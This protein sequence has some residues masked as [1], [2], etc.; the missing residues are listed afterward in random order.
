MENQKGAALTYIE[1]NRQISKEGYS[2]EH[3][4]THEEFEI[5]FAALCYEQR[6]DQRN[7]PGGD[8]DLFMAVPLDWPWDEED[9]KPSPDDRIKELVKAGAL[10]R[11]EVERIMRRLDKIHSLI[12]ELINPTS[13]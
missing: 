12:D 10:Y 3:D 2:I 11:A 9:W 13:K 6:P 7:L 1:R 5:G 8:I 4:D